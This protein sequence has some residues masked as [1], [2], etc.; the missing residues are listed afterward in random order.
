LFYRKP[1]DKSPAQNWETQLRKGVLEMAIL[2]AMR[3]RDRYGIEF[4]DTLRHTAGLDVPEGTL[5]PLL[6]RLV[7][8]G[9]AQT[10]WSA[11]SGAEPPRKY[12]R[13]TD[14]GRLMLGEM[15]TRWSRL[16]QAMRELGEA[17]E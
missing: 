1:V 16:S 3:D 17:P 4:V 14:E 2:F 6:I 7:K 8:D 10:Y 11:P 12:Y 9:W 5:Y 13:I 15:W